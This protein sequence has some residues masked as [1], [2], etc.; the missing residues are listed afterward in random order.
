MLIEPYYNLC[1]THYQEPDDKSPVRMLMLGSDSIK[2]LAQLFVAEV[3]HDNVEIEIGDAEVYI[4]DPN[5]GTCEG[6]QNS[7][8]FQFRYYAGVEVGEHILSLGKE[9]GNNTVP[10]PK[11]PKEVT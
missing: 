1:H 2:E 7:T 10:P 6:V 4:V 5:K 11:R 3:S 9:P 8:L